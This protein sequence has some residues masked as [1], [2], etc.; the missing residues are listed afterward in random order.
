[1]SNNSETLT[2]PRYT[3]EKI[4]GVYEVYDTE[5]CVVEEVYPGTPEGKEAAESHVK[6]LL[7]K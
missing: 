7:Q 2:L 4:N 5:L 3:A 1:M 6:K